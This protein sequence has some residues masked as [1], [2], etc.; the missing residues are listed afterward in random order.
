MF[1]HCF[2]SKWWS[3][4][5]NHFNFSS[6]KLC[7][8][9]CYGN[10]LSKE[11][12]CSYLGVPFAVIKYPLAS[13]LPNEASAAPHTLR[14][15]CSEHL[16]VPQLCPPSL[17]SSLLGECPRCSSAKKRWISWIHQD[18]AQYEVF[19]QGE[20]DVDPPQPPGPS[21]AD[22]AQACADTWGFSLLVQNIVLVIIASYGVLIVPFIAFLKVSLCQIWFSSI[23][24]WVIFP[25]ESWNHLVFP[26]LRMT[27]PSNQSLNRPPF[28]GRKEGLIINRN[29]IRISDCDEKKKKQTLHNGGVFSLSNKIKWK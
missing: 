2:T 10:C 8:A 20:Q 15:L 13:S 3:F 6:C 5:V 27:Q 12:F 9:P 22:C 17:C 24:N 16:G 21:S 28:S 4:S 18:S 11:D 26:Y 25:W 14:N 23:K 19:F 29:S 1:Q 7:F